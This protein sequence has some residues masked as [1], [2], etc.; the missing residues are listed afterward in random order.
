MSD[1]PLVGKQ[2]DEYRLEELLGQGGMAR[3]YRGLDVG[4]NRHAAVKVIDTPF[5]RDESYMRRFEKEAQ[6]IAQLDHPNI[7]NVYRYGQADD[8]LYIAMKYVSGADL[9]TILSGY[10]NG[11]EL[12]EMGE[13]IEIIAAVAE[14]LDY[15]HGKGVVHRDVKP[16]N[17]MLDENGRAYLTDFGLALLTEVGTQGEIFGT[18]QYIAPEQAISS[19]QAVP[20]SDLYAL[21]VILYRMV[22][23]V[24]PFQNDD[25]LEV[26]MQHMTEPPRPPRQIRPELDP[27]LEAVILKAL[28][29]EPA[30]RYP[31]C[32]ALV[33]ALRAA[34]QSTET[35][36]TTAPAL[37]VADRVALD[38]DSLP[39]PASQAETAPPARDKTPST[40]PT[41]QVSWST[42]VGGGVI[43]LLLLL[44]LGGFFLFGGG[45]DDDGAVAGMTTA[46]SSPTVA[47]GN[48][49]P[50]G[51]ALAPTSTPPL[52]T[53]TASPAASP[54]EPAG[55]AATTQPTLA[56]AP[57][58][59]AGGE[60]A[61]SVF[62]AIFLPVIAR[63]SDLEV[64]AVPT[65]PAPATPTVAPSSTEPAATATAVPRFYILVVS[66]DDKTL[67]FT[68]QS[69][70][71]LPLGELRITLD[72]GRDKSFSR[73]ERQALA[74][75][76]CLS[77]SKKAKDASTDLEAI[78]CISLVGDP[79]LFDWKENFTVFYNDVRV[80]RCRLER[81]SPPCE[82]I[83][84]VP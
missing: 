27:A 70:T 73:W 56:A 47:P 26:A 9:Q 50:G 49:D 38:M 25:P 3:V 11:G 37:S 69:Q 67:F 62:P 14:A 46:V 78:D 39:P 35:A 16:S 33:A 52:P 34:V 4:L 12:M 74:A 83:F 51:D 63:Q 31:D 15:A 43:L 29:K 44:L 58:T 64:A 41:V 40:M 54:T 45:G 81:N 61:P 24:L 84:S 13:G 53:S 21:G 82:L 59:T 22:T 32:A 30:E 7:V 42:A 19:A 75:G 72:G 6:A 71:A 23:G 66:R 65:E 8:L 77:M 17:I 68:N 79:L 10:E 28:A 5:R 80:G 1:D 2:L 48:N 60:S 18:P 55:A 57:T 20:A 36:V 76:H